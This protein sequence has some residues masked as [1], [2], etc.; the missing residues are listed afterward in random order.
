MLCL[1]GLGKEGV[2]HNSTR[3]LGHRLSPQLTKTNAVIGDS[4]GPLC[5]RLAVA[6]IG[7][8]LENAAADHGQCKLGS[9]S[10]FLEPQMSAWY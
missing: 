10:S 5:A 9:N 7:L 4:Q 2:E 1:L 8:Q 6:E 3:M